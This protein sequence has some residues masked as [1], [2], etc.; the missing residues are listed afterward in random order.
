MS[1]KNNLR[2]EIMAEWYGKKC[3]E[4]ILHSDIVRYSGIDTELLLRDIV[5]PMITSP[6]IKRC[7]DIGA[8]DGVEGSQTAWLVRHCG[9]EGHFIE[10]S[11]A[12]DRIQENYS[13][14]P[15]KVWR[16]FVTAENVVSLLPDRFD[17]LSIDIDGNDYWVWKAITYKPAVVIIEFN[18]HQRGDWTMP[19]DP[20]FRVSS[21]PPE[22]MYYG[23]SMRS[24]IRLGEEKGYAL[25]AVTSVN[26]IFADMARL[27]PLYYDW[28]PL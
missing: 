12:A 17:Y 28:V 24:L 3:E 15:I 13:G 20:D 19:Y 4:N 11:D 1:F 16:T 10:E 7:V 23:A 8:Y 9:W 22:Q 6:L 27:P 5:F 18:T 21:R 14:M 26:L 25:L 2:R